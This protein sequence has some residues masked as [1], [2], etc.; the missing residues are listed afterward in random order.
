MHAY[1]A[2]FTLERHSMFYIPLIF[3]KSAKRK[4]HNLKCYVF[5]LIPTPYS[6]K[7][8]QHV[9][10]GKCSNFILFNIHNH[11]KSIVNCDY[12]IS[13]GLSNSDETSCSRKCDSNLPH[14]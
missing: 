5:L 6:Y 7:K 14:R 12:F 10:M 9:T 4:I 8:Q 13:M 1:V 11:K 3:D 2:S